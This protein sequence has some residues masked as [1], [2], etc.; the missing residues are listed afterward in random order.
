VRSYS[1]GMGPARPLRDVFAQLG[2]EEHEPHGQGVNPAELLAAHGHPDL[3]DGLVA[4]AVVSYADTA[5]HEVAEHLA[6]Y[7]MAHG[8]AP[9]D[10][11]DAA[12]TDPADWVDLLS[13][14][15]V[16]DDL[17]VEPAGL[18]EAALDL[19]GP[20]ASEGFGVA[21]LVELVESTVGIDLH[22]GC[23]DTDMA[24]PLA[25]T[26]TS[27]EA[28]GVGRAGAEAVGAAPADAGAAEAVGIAPAGTETVGFEAGGTDAVGTEAV[29]VAAP[30]D[31]STDDTSTDDTFTDDTF[32]ND[33][34]TD[35][36]GPDHGGI[37]HV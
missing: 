7:V 13:T 20:T 19:S 31:T 10:D 26:A 36:H 5:P 3:P 23:G 28:V 21:E 1:S 35:D 24:H 15:P 2:G 9:L 17:A 11:A 33:T 30:D 6:P 4:E 14:A 37:D 12:E 22:F 32:T 34:S 25:E 18:D 16:V 27:V 29:G 8:A